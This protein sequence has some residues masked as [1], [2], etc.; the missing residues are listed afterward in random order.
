MIK[1]YKAINCQDK[2]V[3]VE[4]EVKEP[5]ICPICSHAIE[6][7]HIAS[8]YLH[9]PGGL[10][11]EYLFISIYLCRGCEHFFVNISSGSDCLSRYIKA[12]GSVIFPYQ[13]PT[14]DVPENIKTVSPNFVEIYTQANK[15]ESQGLLELVGMGYRKALEFLVKDFAIHNNPDNKESIE[16]C[17]L[18]TAIKKYISNE[19]IQNLSIAVAWLG[20]DETH[21]LKKHEDYGIEHLKNFIKAVMFFINSDLEVEN[22]V[23]LQNRG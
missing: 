6:P 11:A 20:N 23:K 17:S 5:N 7:V 18:S 10:A 8:Y 2:N 14:I 9:N 19:K 4:F 15:A 16:K 21:Y 1:I 22:A 12:N 3:Y 13:E